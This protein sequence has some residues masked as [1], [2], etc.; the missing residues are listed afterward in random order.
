MLTLR[1]WFN[2]SLL[3]EDNLGKDRGTIHRTWRPVVF[4]VVTVD[5]EITATLSIAIWAVVFIVA[6]VVVVTRIAVRMVP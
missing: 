3:C 1:K 5:I 4:T 2:T 6:V